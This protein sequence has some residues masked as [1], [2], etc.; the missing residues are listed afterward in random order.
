[1][2]ERISRVALLVRCLFSSLFFGRATRA[3][4][5]PSVVIVVL[6]G[7]LGDV[8]CCTPVLRALRARLPQARIIAAGGGV[9][10][11]VLTDSGLVDEYLDLES[12]GALARIKACRAEAAVVTGPS[13]TATALLYLAGISLVVAPTVVGGHSP[14]ETRPY[15]LLRRFITTFPY[16]MGEYAP[17]ERLRA[18]EPLGIFSDDIKKQLGF[19]EAADKKMSRFLTDHG[20]DIKKDFV[21]GISASAGNKIKEWP[22]ERFAEVADY[23]IEKHHA[24]VVLTGG[25]G[26]ARKVEGVLK[27]IKNPS[28]VINAQGQCTLDELKALVSKLGL[29]V[30]AD[31]GPIYIAEAFNVPTVDVIGPIDEKEQPPRGRIHRNVVPP[32][33]AR[34]ELFV[35]NARFYDTKEALR[36]LMSITVSAVT[37]EIDVLLRDLDSQR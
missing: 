31:T 34:P 14:S 25:Q 6:T 21:V 28:A 23:L 36:Q 11:A 5:S 15:K 8:V 4:Q 17:R 13:F 35:L 30:S 12:R 26:D 18:L 2:R 19:S 9:L 22:E 10:R 20:I 29:F 1:M 24:K 7:K 27:H 16:R 32:N 33:R 3:P 37:N